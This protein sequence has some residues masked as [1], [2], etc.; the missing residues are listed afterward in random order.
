MGS[1][2][3]E[4]EVVEWRVRREARFATSANQWFKKEFEVGEWR[5][6]KE[7][8]FATCRVPTNGSR[9]C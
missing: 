3:P 6:R 5:V 1:L 4:F 7:A 2:L 8:R 9:K